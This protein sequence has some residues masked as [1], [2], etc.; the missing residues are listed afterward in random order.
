M[1]ELPSDVSNFTTMMAENYIYVDK[2]EYIYNL[3]ISLIQVLM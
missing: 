3:F 1:R 2:T